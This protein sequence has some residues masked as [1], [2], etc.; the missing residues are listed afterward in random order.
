MYEGDR[1]AQEVDVQSFRAEFPL[2]D[3]MTYLNNASYG[4]LPARTVAALQ[5]YV[6][7]LADPLAYLE[8]ERYDLF[9]ETAALVAGM[10]GADAANVCY[11]ASLAD[12]MSLLANG[13]DWRFGDNVLVVEG[14]FPSVVL[15]FRNLQR[16]GVTTRI[17]PRNG[18]G[19]TD[20]GQFEAA[21]DERTRAVA[22]S[23][24]EYLDGYRIDLSALG[25][26]CRARDVELFVDATQSLCV[27]PIDINACGATAL[28]AH[29]FKWMMA[30][31]GIGVVVFAPGA[32]ERIAPM[33]AGRL[34]VNSAF[35][36]PEYQL[37]WRAG[38]ARFQTGGPNLIGLTALHSSLTLVREVGPAW[39]TQHT[40]EL[41]DR[42][43]DG[44]VDSGYRV[45]SDTDPRHRSQIV[46]ISSGQ[47]DRDGQAYAELQRAN[48]LVTLRD[49][50]MRVSPYFYNTVADIDRLLEA[51]PPQ[52]WR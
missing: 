13:V 46:T 8:T 6:A 24:V 26:I 3:S 47:R 20:L 29:A 23:H 34:S 12:G 38:A 15:P 17:V 31:Y 35:G 39:I 41:T 30:S 43:I 52:L 33:S 4:P 22:I 44:V 11:V 32:A 18:E 36:D 49:N 45:V 10:A 25:A 40:R 16:R 48:V 1:L 37:D 2:T 42:L 19:R 5:R 50:G 7:Q 9:G 21:I 51:L 28:V 27:Q 14:E